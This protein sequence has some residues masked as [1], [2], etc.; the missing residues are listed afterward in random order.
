[1]N[2]EAEN[3]RPSRFAGVFQTVTGTRTI[4][5]TSILETDEL[6]VVPTLGS[7]VPNWLLLLPRL[8]TINYR[9]YEKR[10]ATRAMDLIRSVAAELGAS[11]F[12]WFEHGANEPAS[13]TSCG[14]DYAHIHLLLDTPFSYDEFVSHSVQ[15]SNA[16]WR[17]ASPN[18]AYSTIR[19]ASDY[20]TLGNAESCIVQDSGMSLGS[21]FFR[22][23][24][25]DLTL[26]PERWSYREHAFHDNI[27][28]TLERFGKTNKLAA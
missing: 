10:C 22:K 28:R 3:V 13:A 21:Q 19:Q 5:D 18:S 17:P 23:C 1:M 4:W 15:R 8:S 25:A 11:D 14:V 6:V 20:Y 24:V 7:L 26:Q 2:S 12:I 9:E 16:K 27:V